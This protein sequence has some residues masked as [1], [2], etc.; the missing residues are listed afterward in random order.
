MHHMSRRRLQANAAM[1]HRDVETIELGEDLAR[2]MA[3]KHHADLEAKR[4]VDSKRETGVRSARRTLLQSRDGRVAGNSRSVASLAPHTRSAQ[5]FA[6]AIRETAR[7]CIRKEELSKLRKQTQEAAELARRR[8]HS[9]ETHREEEEEK[10]EARARHEAA[11]LQRKLD[12]EEA[13]LRGQL[14]SATEREAQK[15][16]VERQRKAHETLLRETLDARAKERE[17][18]AQQKKAKAEA[19]ELAREAADEMRRKEKVSLRLIREANHTA[20]L[21]RAMEKVWIKADAVAARCQSEVDHKKH[22]TDLLQ[23]TDAPTAAEAAEHL[24]KL[25]RRLELANA[26]VLSAKNQ[27]AEHRAEAAAAERRAKDAVLQVKL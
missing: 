16:D 10:V 22:F 12:F 14:S 23:L 7:D 3:D 13:R 15:A 1:L 5:A 18:R 26:R 24:E 25:L 19:A 20:E 4:M 17:V 2:R 21:A 9:L 27:L 6:E 11:W 8:A